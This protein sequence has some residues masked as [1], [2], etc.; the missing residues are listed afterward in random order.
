MSAADDQ[1][2][3]DGDRARGA[4]PAAR[5][6][7]AAC[8]GP[9]PARTV[10][11]ARRSAPGRASPARRRARRRARHRPGGV[12]RRPPRPP[13]RPLPLLRRRTRPASPRRRRTGCTSRPSTSRRP[14][15]TSWSRCCRTGPHAA[16]RMTQGQGGRRVG[17]PPAPYDAPPD[18]TGEAIGLPASGLTLTFGFGPTL[19]RDATGSD[20]FGLASRQPA[21][22]RELPHFPADNLDPSAL[23]RRPVRAGVRRRPAGRGARHPQPRP[24]R[25]SAR[26]RCAGPSSASAARRRPRPRRSTAA[27]PVRL[28]GRHRQPQGRGPDRR[29]GARLGA[30][31]ATTPRAAWLAGGSYLVARRINMRIETWDRQPAC[32]EQERRDRPRPRP[33]APRCRAARSSPQPNFALKGSGDQ[34]LI[35][36]DAHVRLAHPDAQQRRPAAAP[37]L[38]LRRRQQR[39]SA[40]STPGC[41]SSPTCA[42][43][44]TQYIPMQTRL[45]ARDG[46]MEYLQHT[47]SACSPCRPAR[48]PASYVGQAL[49]A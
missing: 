44:A 9:S 25:A 32:S 37:R 38:Q 30:A 18:D 22:L 27:Q 5:S 36:T 24:D 33:R 31:A 11:S 43:R 48:S 34:P 35:A 12:A 7:G 1:T 23:R 49:F 46:M 28:Q 20:R 3:P 4:P 6:R 17:P 13:G 15:A 26:R 47:G 42:T 14:R 8:C 40:A 41:S 2:T 16:A 45:A 19:F 10:C 29:R 39:A 21:A